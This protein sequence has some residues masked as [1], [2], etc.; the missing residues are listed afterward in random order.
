ME[1]RGL[2]RIPFFS[3]AVVAIAM[4]LL[5][6]PLVELGPELAEAGSVADLLDENRNKLLS[7]VVSFVVIAR[8]WTIHHRIYRGVVGFNSRLVQVNFLWLFSIVFLPFPTELIGTKGGDS[9]GVGLYIG[10]LALTTV[11]LL[12][13][14]VIL[15]R[16]PEL[17]LTGKPTD[18]RPFWATFVVMVMALVIAVAVP[19]IG[20]WALLLLIPAGW[21]GGRIDAPKHDADPA[22]A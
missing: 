2:E 19:D 1:Q 4:T 22:T 5:V 10:T 6:L 16:H 13:Q 3:D 18:L 15:N 21:L 17:S 20:L 14:Q 8:Y 11:A 7:F 9:T 12:L